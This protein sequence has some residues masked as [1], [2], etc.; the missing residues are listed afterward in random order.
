MDIYYWKDHSYVAAV[1]ITK[2]SGFASGEEKAVI[3][4]PREELFNFRDGQ[5][6][7]NI[8]GKNSL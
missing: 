4:E 6:G 3:R 1:L 8:S 7:T 5:I 2:Q